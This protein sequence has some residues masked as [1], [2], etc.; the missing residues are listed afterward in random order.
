MAKSVSTRNGLISIIIPVYNVEKYLRECVESALKQTYQNIEIILVDD[1]STD[2]SS[3]ICDEYVGLDPRIRVVHQENRGPSGARNTGIKM[4]NG[5]YVYFLDSDD[6]IAE[7]T[8]MELYNKAQENDLDV[9]LFDGVVID[10][11]GKLIETDRYY[12]RTGRY[13]R[14]YDGKTIFSEMTG[15]S[16]FRSGVPFL[17]IKKACLEHYH[18]RF[19]E[20]ILHE[21]ELFTF[22][23]LMH[24]RRVT[25]L[26]IPL[27][28]RRRR[29]GSIMTPP[30]NERRFVSLKC[31]LEEM[32]KYYAENAVGPIAEQ[33]VKEHIAKFFAG[34]YNMYRTLTPGEKKINKRIIEEAVYLMKKVGYLNDW[35]IYIICRFA[36]VYE[37]YK[38]FRAISN[39]MRNRRLKLGSYKTKVYKAVKQLLPEPVKSKILTII[40][41]VN[42][43]KKRRRYRRRTLLG[44]RNL[45]ADKRLVLFLSPE[46]GN[47]GGHAIAKAEMTFFKDYLPGV[48]VVEISYP[49]YQYD[50]TGIRKYISRN[51]VLLTNGGGYLGTLWFHDEI[52]VRDIIKSFPDNRIIILP[53]TIFFDATA[54][55]RKQLAVTKAIYSNHRHL[56]FCA[57]EKASYDFVISNE[58]LANPDNCY[59]IPDMVTYLAIEKTTLKREG[60]LLCLRKDK[61]SILNDKLKSEIDAY[62]RRSGEDIHYTDTV[63]N[64]PVS[65]DERGHLLEA[66]FN[67]FRKAKLVITDRLHGML[68]AAITGTPCIALNNKSGKVKGCYETI[69]HLKYIQVI[70]SPPEMLNHIPRLLQIDDCVY[71]NQCLRPYFDKLA[72]LI[73]GEL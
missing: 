72:K 44:F 15:N 33:A 23:L 49:H 50:R 47:L 61:E 34:V 6:Y 22:L 31:I 39:L 46:H 1:G 52:M 8:I 35:R 30:A 7:N 25:H 4:A 63:L 2:G 55:G 11:N 51:D 18:L 60:I 57:R 41:A 29:K 69:K 13:P 14:V 17:F 58:L 45:S 32:I 38:K 56:I 9:V 3:Q 42:K 54:E 27:Y 40:N 28:Y 21:D 43:Q 19:Y 36:F 67:E 16:D 53:Q 24:C 68:F 64:S 20:G 59:L 10:E 37:V 5:D 26:A 65:I 48:P 73:I 70:D 66:K 12:I 62:A 71:D